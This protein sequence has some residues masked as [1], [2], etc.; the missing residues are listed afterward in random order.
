MAGR[1]KP[2]TASRRLGKGRRKVTASARRGGASRRTSPS[3][4][5][6]GGRGWRHLSP[7][8]RPASWRGD[9]R[10]KFAH[11]LALLLQEIEDLRLLLVG[12]GEGGVELLDA[13]LRG[14]AATAA[15]ARG[16]GRGAF[17]GRRGGVSWA[18][19]T[20]GSPKAASSPPTSSSWMDFFMDFEVMR[21]AA[22]MA[23]GTQR[24]ARAAVRLPAL[25]P[26]DKKAGA[27][28]AG[29]IS[30]GPFS[31][32]PCRRGRRAPRGAWRRTWPAARA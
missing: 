22:T 6:S 17:A 19:L 9:P 31:G 21:P 27:R 28:G 1:K 13:G 14:R 10:G 3:A 18:R 7:C 15:T 23:A 2:P 29:W 5:P 26:R 24:D 12:Q 20:A 25:P 30:R 8:S 16:R 32:C 4:H 11:G